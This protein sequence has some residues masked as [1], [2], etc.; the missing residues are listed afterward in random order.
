MKCRWRESRRS[1]SSDEGAFKSF[2]SPPRQLRLS[3]FANQ[4]WHPAW[5]QWRVERGVLQLSVV[6]QHPTAWWL[7]QWRSNEAGNRKDQCFPEPFSVVGDTHSLWLCLQ[8]REDH[9]KQHWNY[10][11]E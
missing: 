6:S 4:N 1:P 7:L 5:P 9:Q 2:A 11:P 8:F 10:D 3:G